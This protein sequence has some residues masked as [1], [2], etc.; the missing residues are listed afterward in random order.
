MTGEAMAI[1]MIRTARAA[2]LRPDPSRA[3]ECGRRFTIGCGSKKTKYCS[4]RCRLRA[5]MRASAARR[6][7]AR[8]CPKCSGPIGR[9]ARPEARLCSERCRLERKMAQVRAGVKRWKAIH[10]DRAKLSKRNTGAIRRARKRGARVEAVDRNRVFSLAQGV[11][12][13]CELPIDVNSNWHVDHDIPLS[14]GGAHSYANTQPAHADCNL[15]KGSRHPTP[16]A[17]VLA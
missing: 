2:G 9:A 10:I 4:S 7:A 12:G 6:Q 11:C 1:S 17:E 15:K 14:R 3:C 13:I 8:S 16:P 5:D